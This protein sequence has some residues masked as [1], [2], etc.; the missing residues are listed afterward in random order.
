VTDLR[1]RGGLMVAA[2]CQWMLLWHGAIPMIL[3]SP[4]A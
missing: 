2:M 1:D 3:T 4:K